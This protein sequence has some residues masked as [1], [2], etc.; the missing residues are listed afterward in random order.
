[1]PECR[2][3]AYISYSHVDERWA[4]WL[5]HALETYRVPARLAAGRELPKRLSP[6][7]RDREDLSSASNLAESLVE[8]LNDSDAMIVVCSPAAA[9][10]RWVNEEI[11]RFRELGR[12]E[13][14]FCMVVEGD[15][16]SQSTGQTCFPPAL[17]EAGGDERVEPLAADAREFADGKLLAKL[18]LVAALLG[19]CLDELRQRDLMRRR[20]W[21]VLGALVLMAVVALGVITV[22]SLL[23]E[24]RERENAKQMA[25]FVVELGEDLQSD[26]DLDTLGRISARAMDYLQELDPRKLTPETSIK[27]GLALRQLGHVN[28]GQAK[29]PESL[30]AYRQSLE[31]FRGLAEKH[32]DRTDISFELAQAEFYVG[33]YHYE[34]GKI[35]LAWEPWQR[36]LA[37]AQ[38]LYDAEPSNRQWMLEL[39]YGRMNIV[40][41]RVRSGKSADRSLLKAVIESVELSRRTLKAW[42]DN[43]EVISHYSNVLAWAA[44][45]ELLACHLGTATEYRRETLEMAVEASRSDPS[46]NYLRE[47][48][49]YAHSGMAKVNTNLGITGDAEK[50]LQTTLQILGELWAKDPSNRMLASEIAANKRLLA[51]LLMNTQR[52]EMAI[53]LVQE[54]KSYIESLPTIEDLTES[55]AND[56]MSFMNDYS[57]LMIR[58]G[59]ETQARQALAQLSEIVNHLISKGESRLAINNQAARLRYL[60][61][62]LDRRD[63]ALDFPALAAAK[64]ESQSEFR[65]CYDA[66]LS[67]RLAIVEGDRSSAARQAEYLR[68]RNY[69]NPDFIRFC[70]SFELCTE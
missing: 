4:T 68:D 27:V 23:S 13:R 40:L 51:N 54:V 18:K 1:M 14:I 47:R 38:E 69:R 61:F 37:I 16:G 21:R 64:P 30:A 36:Y 46:N 3:K 43:S 19:V 50:H 6:I 5:Q 17:L 10:S 70:K 8:A 67:A 62:A 34:Q 58:T 45:A 24:Q 2:Y 11:L 48:L 35:Q 60:G 20:R 7:F 28:Q 53:L 9:Q 41:L 65:S 66:D 59:N 56:Y 31:L 25:T 42:P 55:E 22:S 49:A 15:P 44:D 33:N 12:A 57:D 52:L 63:P 26:V 32:P 39:S 29:L